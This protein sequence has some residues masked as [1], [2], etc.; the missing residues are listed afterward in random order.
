MFVYV[1]KNERKNDG[2]K[3]NGTQSLQ[4]WFQFPP[5]I[6]RLCYRSKK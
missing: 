4:K 5:I 3:E 2:K 1:R 6:C